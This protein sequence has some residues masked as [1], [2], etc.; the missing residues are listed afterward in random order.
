MT[1]VVITVISVSVNKTAVRIFTRVVDS[2]IADQSVGCENLR[3]YRDIA[4]L[5]GD[6][7]FTSSPS[8]ISESKEKERN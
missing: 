3:S 6:Y 5:R 2:V 8:V 7:I 1:T 4:F